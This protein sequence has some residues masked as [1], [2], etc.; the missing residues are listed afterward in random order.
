MGERI[1]PKGMSVEDAAK[2]QAENIRRDMPQNRK[3]PNIRESDRWYNEL[4]RVG[5]FEKGR[6]LPSWAPKYFPV[7][8]ILVTNRYVGRMIIPEIIEG[9]IE[10]AM[11]QQNHV[12]RHYH[13]K[14]F[15]QIADLAKDI[16]DFSYNFVEKG[17]N[18][19]RLEILGEEIDELFKLYKIE[20]PRSPFIKEIVVK[21]SKSIAR[22][23]L[24][25]INPL[26]S[27]T[28]VRSAYWN[29][30]KQ[31]VLGSLAET[32]SAR[33]YDFLLLERES[34]RTNLSIAKEYLAELYHIFDNSTWT[35]DSVKWATKELN[36]CSRNM[37]FEYLR[38]VRL[39]PYLEVARAVEAIVL[40]KKERY[41]DLPYTL[42]YYGRSELNNGDGVITKEGKDQ[43]I[44]DDLAEAHNLIK[45]ILFN[46][47][48]QKISAE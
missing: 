10:D 15:N 46:P 24:G 17:L 21:L 4:P 44:V 38:P 32:K 18:T 37:V 42:N 48:Y 13:D 2:L 39:A 23:S 6:E 40:P 9:G 11:R 43:Y 7:S 33:I 8:G 45:Q 27:R 1:N 12:N 3:N 34:M 31:E 29:A 28:R 16:H 35:M 36:E 22:D 25:R 5:A 14:E 19:E 26:V 41:F 47:K 30:I 20:K